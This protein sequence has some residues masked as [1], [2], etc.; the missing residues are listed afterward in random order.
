VPVGELPES[1]EQWAERRPIGRGGYFVTGLRKLKYQPG[2]RGDAGMIGDSHRRVG[3]FA[4][5]LGH[6]AYSPEGPEW[7]PQIELQRITVVRD[8]QTVA[9]AELP[10]E[11]QSEL[12]RDFRTLADGEIPRRG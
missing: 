6:D 12:L 11:L 3:R 5:G 2:L 9:L 1:A 8:E 4:I 7:T 10:P